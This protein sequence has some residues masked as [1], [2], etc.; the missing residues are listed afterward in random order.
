MTVPTI[1]STTLRGRDDEQTH[2]T[3]EALGERDDVREQSPLV[4]RGRALASR[5]LAD[6]DVEQPRRHDHDVPIA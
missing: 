5:L 2:R 4:R 3:T 6:V 1:A